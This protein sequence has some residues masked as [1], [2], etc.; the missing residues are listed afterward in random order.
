MEQSVA[1]SVDIHDVSLTRGNCCIFDNISLIVP[2]G[3]ITAVMEPSDTGKTTLLRLIGEQTAPD[4]GE[5]FFGGESIPA[6]S[7][8]RLYTVRKRMGMLFQFG[9]LFADMNVF[10]NVTYPLREYTRLPASLLYSTVMTKLEAVGLRRTA[11]LMPFKPSDGIARRAAL[12][13]TIAL[14]PDLIMSDEPLI[15]QDPIAM[16][17][18]MKPISGLNSALDVTCVMAS[19]DVPGALSTVDHAWILVD[20]KIVTHGSV[21]AL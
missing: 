18:P 1:N 10:D 17:V 6:M 13:R 4:H 9:A 12:A 3:K 15:R 11:K 16:D 19:H 21:Q 14:E 7:R 20:K 8:S 2:R 5:A